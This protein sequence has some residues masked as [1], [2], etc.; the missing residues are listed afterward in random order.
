MYSKQDEA[1][2]LELENGEIKFVTER[3]SFRN[4]SF[5]QILNDFGKA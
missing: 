5:V 3:K 1:E 4:T 2:I